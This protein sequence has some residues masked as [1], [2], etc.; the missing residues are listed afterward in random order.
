[1]FRSFFDVVSATV[2]DHFL[3][4]Y[5]EENHVSLTLSTVQMG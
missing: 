1:M 5:R 2:P 3:N 4:L